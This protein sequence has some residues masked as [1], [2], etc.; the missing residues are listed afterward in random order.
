MSADSGYLEASSARSSR[1]WAHR[2][3]ASFAR[4]LATGHDGIAHD[5]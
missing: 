1:A 4:G 3:P 5:T 2:L